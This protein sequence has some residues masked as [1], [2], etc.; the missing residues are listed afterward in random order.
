MIK[1][2]RNK[3]ERRPPDRDD[4]TKILPRHESEEASQTDEPV[5][6]NAS[7]EDL[8]PSRRDDLSSRERLCFVVVGLGAEDATVPRDNGHDE[9]RSREVSEE[10]HSPVDQHFEN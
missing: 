3:S 7:E 6:A 8:V 5:G 1:P 4:F 9:E 10:G 2:Q